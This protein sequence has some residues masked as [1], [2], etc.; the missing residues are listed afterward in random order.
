MSALPA[1]VTGVLASMLVIGAT[2]QV[3]AMDRI[4]DEYKINGFA[5][6]CQAWSFNNFTVFDAIRL[7]H[8][9]GGKIIEFFPGQALSPDHRDVKFDHNAPDDVIEQVQAECKKYGVL[10]VNYG[11]V[12]VHGPQQWRKV[13]EF[14]HK[15]NLYG[16]TSEPAE[17][18]MDTIESLVKEFDIHFCIHDHP[19]RPNDPSYKFWDPHYVLSLVK[20]R[21]PRMGSCADTGHWLTSGVDPIEALH[22]LKGRVM[23]SHLKDRNKKG[24][25]SHDVAWGSGVGEVKQILDELKAQNFQGNVNI[26]FENEMGPDASGTAPRS[27]PQIKESLTWLKNS[28]DHVARR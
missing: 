26:E 3:R 23:S 8:E 22:I 7:T 9:A 15:M 12:T 27:F 5:A 4:P 13:F 21:D 19:K 10:P 16:V 2:R 18:D 14:A 20:N 17:D 6:G 1:W 25:G 24:R 11:V 28:Y